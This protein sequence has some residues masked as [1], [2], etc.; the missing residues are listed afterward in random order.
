MEIVVVSD[1]PV[2]QDHYQVS[3]FS[4]IKS[5]TLYQSRHRLYLM[6]ITRVHRLFPGGA[7]EDLTIERWNYSC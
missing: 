1:V 4:D 2:D 3:V 7:T 5:S 6:V